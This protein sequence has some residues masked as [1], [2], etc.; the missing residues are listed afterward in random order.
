M[1]RTP[2]YY[3]SHANRTAVTHTACMPVI[4]NPKLVLEHIM[5]D[6]CLN[7]CLLKG[8]SCAS[9]SSMF[10]SHLRLQA[11]VRTIA[12]WATQATH[13]SL[14]VAN[15]KTSPLIFPSSS[16]KYVH[17][18]R[19]LPLQEEFIWYWS[20]KQDDLEVKNSKSVSIVS[21]PFVSSKRFSNEYKH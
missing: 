3:V 11:G 14:A 9:P 12:V 18:C 21:S 8:C 4:R 5:L 2:E 19:V 13:R 20:L 6:N 10:R 7:C 17:F 16:R 15:R 1:N